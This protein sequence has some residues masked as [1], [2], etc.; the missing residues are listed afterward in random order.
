MRIARPLA[1]LLLVA[2]GSACA[3]D[4]QPRSSLEELRV[5]AIVADPLELVLNG[6][7]DG[8]VTLTATTFVPAGAT[9][10]AQNWSFCPF[11][12]GPSAGYACIAPSCEF[13]VG[14]G[15]TVTPP[16]SPYAM[17]QACL[18]SLG[19]TPPPGTPTQIP[20]P[21][22]VLFRY[23]VT[24][25]DGERREA[26]QTIPVYLNGQPAYPNTAPVIQEV[27]IGGDA[28]ASGGTASQT[29]RR[30]GDLSVVVHLDPASAQLYVDATGHTVQESLVVSFYVTD[31]SFDHDRANGPDASATLQG[32]TWQGDPLAASVASVTVY[33]VARDLRG[34]QAVAGPFT[35]NVS[36]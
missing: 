35:V 19:A 7:V 28:V 15:P 10:T 8:N 9:I 5:L 31:A 20:D 36:P 32:K 29:L 25:S 16:Q 11:S 13:S 24:T 1:P 2:L 3:P 21:V 17:A 12:V 6:N 34:G 22:D 4:L 14:S 27:D 30:G 18:A 23:V 33:A 26:V